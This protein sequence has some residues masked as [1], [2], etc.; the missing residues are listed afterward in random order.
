MKALEKMT[1]RALL[2]RFYPKT[3]SVKMEI[4]RRS[5]S[6]V[7]P[8]SVTNNPKTTPKSVTNNPRAT[9]KSVT[10]VTLKSVTNDPTVCPKPNK[11]IDKPPLPSPAQNPT[12]V[13]CEA[14][15]KI[16]PRRSPRLTPSK[17][18]VYG[19]KSPTNDVTFGVYWESRLDNQICN[20]VIEFTELSISVLEIWIKHLYEE[21][22]N[23]SGVIPIQ[24][25]CIA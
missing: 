15:S 3:F 23:G 25:G 22:D 1:G 24:F 7:T 5:P 9:P 20:E 4:D 17:R 11:T 13:D 8:K 19:R 6:K 10:K 14:T 12:P 18:K 21:I 16:T 2:I